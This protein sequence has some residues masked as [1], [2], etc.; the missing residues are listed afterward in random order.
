MTASISDSSSTQTTSPMAV[1]RR[2]HNA[3]WVSLTLGLAQ[4]AV[5][6]RPT[7]AGV[8]GIDR[9]TAASAPSAPSKKAMGRPAAIDSATAP[10]A[11]TGA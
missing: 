6:P 2:W 9:T 4:A 1:N 10:R 3:R 8:F 7:A 11:E 5:M